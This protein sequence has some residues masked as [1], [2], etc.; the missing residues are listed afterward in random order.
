MRDETVRY[1]REQLPREVHGQ[2]I[3]FVWSLIDLNSTT[4]QLY[5]G[6]DEQ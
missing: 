2:D 5:K 3:T 4:T 1:L 6:K